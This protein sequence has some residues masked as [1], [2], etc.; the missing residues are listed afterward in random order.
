MEELATRIRREDC[1]PL[2]D[3]QQQTRLLPRPLLSA[4]RLHR[5]S[6]QP[7]QGRGQGTWSG[8]ARNPEG[9]LDD[10]RR[11][12]LG[13]PVQ[14]HRPKPALDLR[15]SPDGELREPQKHP[16]VLRVAG[17]GV[18]PNY[19]IVKDALRNHPKL[20][21]TF[22][23]TNKTWG[24]VIFREGLARL[25]AEHPDRFRLV[26]T[27]TRQSDLTGLPGDV[28]PGRIGA[29][30]LRELI[31]DSATAFAYLCG[32]AIANWDRKKALEGG[33]APTPRFLESTIANLQLV[34]FTPARI[35]REAYG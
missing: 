12:W 26:H 5:T 3:S 11:F 31:P 24:D 8:S 19:S 4:G 2:S 14:R 25:A 1:F 28:R 16:L 33:T 29:E 6:P 23:D 35:K 34:G 9:R 15:P 30:L 32:P 17:S 13:Y 22:I 18:V 10:E 20:R 27:L 21:H 7:R